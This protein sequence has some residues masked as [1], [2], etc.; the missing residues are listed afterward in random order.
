[1]RVVEVEAVAEHAVGER[2]GGCRDAVGAADG[3]GRTRPCVLRHGEP[4]KRLPDA[5]RGEPATQRVEDVVARDRTYLGGHVGEF[6]DD[7]QAASSCAAA[8]CSVSIVMS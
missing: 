7:V 3:A 1:M 4:G 5:E 8:R 6:Q 2:G